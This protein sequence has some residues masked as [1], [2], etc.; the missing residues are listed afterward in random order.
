MPGKHRQK[1]QEMAARLKAEKEERTTGVC[2][3][4][5]VVISVDSRRSRY[6]HPG[7]ICRGVSARR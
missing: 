7:G 6:S 2:P 1:D 4:C 3:V 5:Y